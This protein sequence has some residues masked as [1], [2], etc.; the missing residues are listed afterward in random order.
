M[1]DSSRCAE[2]AVFSVKLN[3]PLNVVEL[4]QATEGVDDEELEQARELASRIALF[5][6]R[7][8]ANNMFA[9]FWSNGRALAGRLTPQD[10]N[11]NGD[12]FYLE[13]LFMDFELFCRAGADP[14]TFNQLAL[15]TTRFAHYR[16]N[17]VLR[18][19]ELNQSAS[20]V[21]SESVYD[22]IEK[23]GP[24]LVAAM[25]QTLLERER[26]LFI[27]RYR[28][29][30][31][32]ATL[33]SL[34]PVHARGA[35]SFAASVYFRGIGVRF[36][37]ASVPAQEPASIP[38]LYPPPFC[39]DLRKI[40]GA[41]DS[42]VIKSSWCDFVERILESYA[43]PYL[44][45]RLRW[46][47]EVDATEREFL[48][49]PFMTSEEV[50]ALGVECLEELENTDG[51]ERED[52]YGL[53]DA[54]E[55]TK[56]EL[57]GE[58]WK[59]SGEQRDEDSDRSGSTSSIGRGNEPSLKHTIQIFQVDCNDEMNIY[60]SNAT[61]SSMPG[62]VDDP[63]FEETIE[64]QLNRI[65][66]ETAGRAVFDATSDDDEWLRDDGVALAPFA[67]LTAKFPEKEELLR[68]LD[69]LVRE[70]CAG[71]NSVK[72]ELGTLWRELAANSDPDFFLQ[73]K[74]EYLRH[75]RRRIFW[76]ND[77]QE[78]GDCALGVLEVLEF[79]LDDEGDD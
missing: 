30:P 15:N 31:L 13:C 6:G 72:S 19:L 71:S 77:P 43:L 34:L 63:G 26:T 20:F 60:D 35:L 38:Q 78:C 32:V 45:A 74:E 40:D 46:R 56:D 4:M 7:Y 1:S 12:A 39:V 22:S 41:E 18:P 57:D 21:N 33:F 61:P 9:F 24:R 69:R 28:P 14:V 65:A 50:D 55:R 68:R 5:G 58:E 64:E 49:P 37:A 42:I 54:W 23:I 25:L 66:R 70:V 17:S 36:M 16:R 48:S 62:D 2:Q 44:E 52:L 47:Y 76:S 29:L 11:F 59:K 53:F 10:E 75:L 79:F 73:V 67:V 3:S 27:S 51:S 8:Y